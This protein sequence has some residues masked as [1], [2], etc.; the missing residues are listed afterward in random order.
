M[1]PGKL[2][3]HERRLFEELATISDFDPRSER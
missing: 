3:D 1:V 2:N